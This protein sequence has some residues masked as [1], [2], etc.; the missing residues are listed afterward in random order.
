MLS[1]SSEFSCISTARSS[2]WVS[3]GIGRSASRAMIR[4]RSWTN[5]SLFR[6]TRLVMPTS[7]NWGGVA[8]EIRSKVAPLGAVPTGT[9]YNAAGALTWL[10][11][12]W[13]MP[14]DQFEPLRTGRQMEL[15]LLPDHL[16]QLLSKKATL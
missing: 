1:Y 3:A 2:C 15:T 16:F 9:Q 13:P 11:L 12:S 7:V 4:T 6:A 8:S 10:L 14:H 5:C